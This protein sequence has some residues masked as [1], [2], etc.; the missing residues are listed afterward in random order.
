[1]D[2]G[3]FIRTQRLKAGYT[4]RDIVEMSGDEMDKTTVSRIERN[5]R[6]M[7]LKAAFIFSEIFDIDMKALAKKS[8]GEEVKVKKLNPNRKKVRRG[9]PPK[10]A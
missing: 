2:F 4:I 9:R 5:E 1:M 3:K 10:N 8:F 7:S 6:K